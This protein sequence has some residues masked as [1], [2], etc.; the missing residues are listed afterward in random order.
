MGRRGAQCVHNLLLF[1]P[2]PVRQIQ[3]T[4][5]NAL[6]EDIIG[7]LCILDRACVYDGQRDVAEQVGRVK[8]GFQKGAGRDQ[9]ID[10]LKG[11]DQLSRVPDWESRDL[12]GAVPV[13]REG[14]PVTQP[15]A[16]KEIAAGITHDGILNTQ[17]LEYP[18]IDQRAQISS[19]DQH[20]APRVPGAA[21]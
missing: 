15:A 19:A 21:Q 14:Y 7:L 8:G 11:F 16:G 18:V 13:A 20:G 17:L 2:H 4:A 6:L 5:A 9:L 1:C 12:F 3:R 10:P